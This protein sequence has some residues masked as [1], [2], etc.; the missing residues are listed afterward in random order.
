MPPCPAFRTLHSSSDQK[1]EVI[2]TSAGGQ[3]DPAL[4]LALSYTCEPPWPDSSLP[5]SAE[6][7]LRALL[8]VA[9]LQ[10]QVLLLLTQ[11]SDQV[12]LHA[13]VQEVPLHL[14][15]AWQVASDL[16]EDKTLSMATFTFEILTFQGFFLAQ[17]TFPI[18]RAAD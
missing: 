3:E 2:C 12:L 6:P 10:Q 8:I 14:S 17:F 4:T 9:E 7:H 18:H 13:R 11:L 16:T 5:A 15:C 1:A